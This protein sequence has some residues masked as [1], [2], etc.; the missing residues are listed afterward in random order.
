MYVFDALIYNEDRHAGNILF[1]PSD[2]KVHLI[3]HTRA[4]R[5]KTN[6]PDALRKVTLSPTPELAR[7]IAEMD[8]DALRQALDGL[9]QSMQVSS[10]LKRRKKLV[11]EW[12]ELGLLTGAEAGVGR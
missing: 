11:A 8:D 6:R 10:I 12:T 1:T 5:T 4:F 7:A 3:D 9:V 2:W